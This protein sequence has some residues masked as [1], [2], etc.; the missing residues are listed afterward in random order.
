[1]W[2]APTALRCPRCFV[3]F[4]DVIYHRWGIG[5][6]MQQLLTSVTFFIQQLLLSLIY[7]PGLQ[8]RIDICRVLDEEMCAV[9]TR[10]WIF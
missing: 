8:V 7:L 10:H 2:S 4:G 1:V 5:I 9:A 6:W 3:S